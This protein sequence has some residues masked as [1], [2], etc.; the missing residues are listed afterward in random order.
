MAAFKQHVTFSSVLGV[1]YAVALDY[2]GINWVHSVLAGGLCGLAGMLPDLDSASGRP[3]RELFGFTAI[4]VPLLLSRRLLRSG[5]EPEQVVLAGAALYLSIRFGLAW[6]FRHL[7]V[8]R[9]MFHSIPAAL[10]AGEAV[11]LAD[12]SP[13]YFGRLTLAGGI[14]LGFLSHLVLDEIYSVDLSGMTPRLN[15]AAGSAVKFFSKSWSATL[16]TWLLLGLLT[17]LIGVELRL[18]R[19]LDIQ[20]PAAVTALLP[21]DHHWSIPN[22]VPR[23]PAPG[24]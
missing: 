16:A 2:S 5:I 21:K 7:T 6:L 19:P 20:L 10:I 8:H 12:D 9:G 18:V 13:E 22:S 17:Y 24:R 4:G 14:M 11:F 3:A 15:K 1:G 23:V